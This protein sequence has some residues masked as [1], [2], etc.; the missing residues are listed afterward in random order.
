MQYKHRFILIIGLCLSCICAMAQHRPIRLINE[1]QYEAQ[2]KLVDE[3]IDRFNNVEM[4]R[5][6]LCDGMRYREDSIFRN[7][8][9]TLVRTIENNRICLHFNDSD[10]YAVVKCQYEMSGEMDSLD[11]ILSVEPRGENLYKWV[12]ADVQGEFLDLGHSEQKNEMFI[13]PHQHEMDFSMLQRITSEKNQYISLFAKNNSHID[14]FSVFAA[15]VYTNHLKIQFVK[16]VSFVFL[17]VPGFRFT[18]RNFIRDSRNSGWLIN[19]IIPIGRGQKEYL[20]TIIH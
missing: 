15:L 19:D 11:L 8:C 5:L 14:R 2:V 20:Q 16:D 7:L 4:N 3:F 12:I 10:W 18:I 13:M 17:Q 1:E 6:L 9:D